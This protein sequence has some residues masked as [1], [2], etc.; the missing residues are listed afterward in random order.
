MNLLCDIIVLILIWVLVDT[1]SIGCSCFLSN[2]RRISIII[3]PFLFRF[4]TI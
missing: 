4:D 2:V 1:S 3:I